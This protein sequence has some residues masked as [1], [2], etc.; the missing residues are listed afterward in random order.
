MIAVRG[1]ELY[2]A[3]LMTAVLCCVLGTAEG[4]LKWSP[5]SIPA[6]L[7][8]LDGVSASERP[9]GEPD[10]GVGRAEQD[11]GGAVQAIHQLVAT[12]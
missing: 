2:E 7:E 4:V 10:G 1:W 11:D 5:W 8:R 9:D 12:Y 3:L 6:G